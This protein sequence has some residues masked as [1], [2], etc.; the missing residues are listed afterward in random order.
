MSGSQRDLSTKY[1]SPRSLMVETICLLQGRDLL[2]IHR[3]TGIPFY[4]LK[5][6]SMGRIANP[7]VN[8]IQYLYENLKG[9]RIKLE[10]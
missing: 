8:R 10:R 3:E 6:L 1:D 2:K 9:R 4:W 5:K 7:S